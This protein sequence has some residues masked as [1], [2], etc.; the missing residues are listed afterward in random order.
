VFVVEQN[1]DAQLRSMLS[2]ETGIPTGRMHSVRRYGGIPMSA[3]FVTEGVL[4]G[5]NSATARL[6]ATG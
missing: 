5:L 3:P 1:R 6:E 4:A 2:L